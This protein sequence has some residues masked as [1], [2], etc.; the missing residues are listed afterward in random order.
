MVTT[1]TDVHT[2]V[3]KMSNT[4]VPTVPTVT[5]GTHHP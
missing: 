4:T 5:A 1:F 3:L 2:N